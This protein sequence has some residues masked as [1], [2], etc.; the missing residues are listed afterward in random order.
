[1][2]I[3]RDPRIDC[4]ETAFAAPPVQ[5]VPLT[6]GGFGVFEFFLPPPIAMSFDQAPSLGEVPAADHLIY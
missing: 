2:I 5:G 6:G 1:M 3:T 4:H